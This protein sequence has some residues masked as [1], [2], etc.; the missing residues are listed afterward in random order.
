MHRTPSEHNLSA[1]TTIDSTRESRR[2]RRQALLLLNVVGGIAVLASYVLWLGH[3]SNRASALWGGVTG[4]WQYLYT[5][6]MFAATAGYLVLLPYLARYVIDHEWLH[7]LFALVLF[8]SA[9][10]MPLTFEY[11]D[12]PTTGLW[13]AL[14]CDLFTVAAASVA[15]VVLTARTPTSAP[16]RTRALALAGSIAFTFQ[17]AVLDAFVW[18]ALFRG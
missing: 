9:L 1:M 10:W 4:S 16:A 8:P 18:P 13:I 2:G 6:S 7:T 3:P 14:R 12:G 11:V 5:I 17:T 15:L